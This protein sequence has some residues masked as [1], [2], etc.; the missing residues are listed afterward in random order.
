MK[1]K[2][3]PFRH[4]ID[5]PITVAFKTPPLYS[6]IPHC[7]DSITWREKTYIISKSL[8]E[9]KDYSRRGKM[10]RNMRP[11]HEQVAKKRG[12][13]GVARFFYEVQTETGQIFLLYY[14]RAPSKLGNRHGNW[15]LLAEL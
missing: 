4:F 11:Q 7:P 6:K 12:S 13:W 10:S 14:D 9:W 8:I 1:S 2:R 5:E 15:I 3:T